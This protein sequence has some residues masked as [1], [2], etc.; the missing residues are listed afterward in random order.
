MADYR[1]LEVW[2]A[3]KDL[4]VMA[5]S[6]TAQLPIDEKY[7][8]RSQIQ[9]AA[10][11]VAAN[12]AE[13][14]GRDSDLDFARFVRMAIGSL[15]ELD[16]LVQIAVDLGQTPEPEDMNAAVRDLAVRLRNLAKKLK[17]P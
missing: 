11:S 5:Y 12:I 8:L 17:Q 9:R 14:A 2:K 6:L 3:A 16:T 15:N 10:V 7:G 4:A 13:G 1:N